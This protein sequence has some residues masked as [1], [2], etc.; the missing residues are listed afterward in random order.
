MAGMLSGGGGI[1]LRTS[2]RRLFRILLVSMASEL[3]IRICLT[4]IETDKG[5]PHKLASK[6]IVKIKEQ[7]GLRLFFR[8]GRPLVL[9]NNMP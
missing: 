9:I 6:I 3:L 1:F 8:T 2:L 7:L 5:S 4:L